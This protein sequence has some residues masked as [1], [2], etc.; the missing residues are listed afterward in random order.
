[1]LDEDEFE[2]NEEEAEKDVNKGL[3]DSHQSGLKKVAAAQRA[4]PLGNHVIGENSNEESINSALGLDSIVQDS[5]SPLIDECLESVNNSSQFQYAEARVG[6]NQKQGKNGG[7]GDNN[8][9]QCDSNICVRA[10]QVHGINLHV[11]LNPS[12]VRR[13]SINKM[14]LLPNKS[15]LS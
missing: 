12:A 5:Q 9:V 2:N 15:S 6:D 8:S 13:L 1:M 11:D 10:S 7:I 14:N 3:D 4:M